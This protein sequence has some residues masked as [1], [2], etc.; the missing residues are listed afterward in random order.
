MV[1]IRIKL[2]SIVKDLDLGFDIVNGM[3][4]NKPLSN[5]YINDQLCRTNWILV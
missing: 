4:Q 3:Y 2:E 5:I 1:C